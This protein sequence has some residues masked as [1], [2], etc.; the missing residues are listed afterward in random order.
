MHEQGVLRHHALFCTAR[1]AEEQRFLDTD[2]ADVRTVHELS[3]VVAQYGAGRR[4][5]KVDD[6]VDVGHAVVPELRQG[7]ERRL[8][9]CGGNHVVAYVAP[10]AAQIAQRERRMPALVV[11]AKGGA[12]EIDAPRDQAQVLDHREGSLIRPVR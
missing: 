6:C 8:N 11:V 9:G 12:G 10:E 1:R 4:T 5:E 7:V 3:L 2:D